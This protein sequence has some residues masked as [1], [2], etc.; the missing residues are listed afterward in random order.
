MSARPISRFAFPR[1]T[2]LRATLPFAMFRR[3][4]L[5][6]TL[7]LATAAAVSAAD[8]G[9]GSPPT[10]TP[11]TQ[12][13][14]N[15]KIWSPERKMCLTPEQIKT[16]AKG[17]NGSQKKSEAGPDDILYEAAREFA[18]AGQFGHALDTLKA[19]QDQND[20]RILNYYGFTYRKLG[21]MQL[22][23]SYYRRALQA[24]E[25]YVLARSYMGQALIQQGDIEGAR[26]QLVEIRDRGGQDSWAY[27]SLLQSLGGD[28][29][30]Y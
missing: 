5:A 4:A 7:V 27:R 6:S 20:P 28:R 29:S 10:P 19:A 30:R 16:N 22:A 21:R 25:N 2:R 12:S 14:T 18:Y 9:S 15:G 26:V 11:T 3:A 13:C 17:K 1:A 8:S 24:D 23:M